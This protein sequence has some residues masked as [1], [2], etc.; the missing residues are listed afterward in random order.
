MKMLFHKRIPFLKQELIPARDRELQLPSWKSLRNLTKIRYFI[1]PSEVTKVI[2]PISQR[3]K[4]FLLWFFFWDQRHNTQILVAL[5][6]NG[7]R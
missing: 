3:L 4:G 1:N 2:Y 7:E 5:C 6:H